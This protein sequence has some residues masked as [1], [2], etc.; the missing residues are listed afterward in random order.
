MHPKTK[1][2]ANHNHWSKHSLLPNYKQKK[3]RQ[4]GNNKAMEANNVVVRK[5]GDK[6]AAADAPFPMP[7]LGDGVGMGECT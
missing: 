5:W 3:E 2:T 1:N 4:K 7:V 6:S